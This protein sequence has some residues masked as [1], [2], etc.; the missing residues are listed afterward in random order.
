MKSETQKLTRTALI[1]VLTALAMF[2]TLLVRVPVPATTGYFN[3]G[4]IFVILAGLWLG[5]WAGLIVGAVGPGLADAVG[6][7]QFILAT[8]VT[9]GLEGFVV[10]LIGRGDR[11][12][13]WRKVIAAIAGGIIIVVGYFLF[14]AFVYPALATSIPLFAVTDWAAALVEILPNSIQ[15]FVGIVGGVA[16]WKAVSGYGGIGPEDPPDPE[17]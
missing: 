10:G 16:L 4:D 14:E 9:K 13:L 12:P 3:I 11:A 8:S 1:A 15:A 5:P 7:P 2:S 17:S 6:F